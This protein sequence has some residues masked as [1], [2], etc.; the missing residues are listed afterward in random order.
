MKAVVQRVVKASVSVNNEVVSSIGRGLCVLIGISRDDTPKDMEYM[1]RK[2]LNLRLFDDANGKRWNHSIKDK[3]FEILCVSQM[4][5]LVL[6]CK[7]IYKMMD[8]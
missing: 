7:S 4:E 1:V 5:Y 8:L 2:V 3:G 6:T